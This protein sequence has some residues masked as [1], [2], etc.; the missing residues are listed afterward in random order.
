MSVKPVEERTYGNLQV[1][2][3]ATKQDL[4]MAAAEAAAEHVQAL[5]QQS[6]NVNLMFSTGASQFEFVAALQDQKEVDWSRIAAFHLDEYKDMS[7]QHPASFRLWLRTRVEEPL[8]PGLFHYIE[9]DAPDIDAELARYTELLLA[10]PIDLGFIGIGE[11]GHIAFNDPPV[12]DF[13]DPKV[14]KIVELD[15]AC[16]RQQL[17]E[18]WFPTLDDVPKEALSL[19]IPTIMKCRK[20][21]SVVPDRRKAEAVKNALEGPVATSCPASVLRTHADVTLFLDADSASLLSR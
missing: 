9:G 18:G 16:R 12:A 14:I 2:V 17:G 13:A 3:F 5:Q 7:D 21:I 8:K 11:N 19:T 6:D 10:N 15:E 20:I 1:K 4:G